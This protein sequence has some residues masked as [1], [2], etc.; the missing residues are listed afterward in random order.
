MLTIE[1]EA[2]LYQIYLLF[3]YL[4]KVILLRLPAKLFILCT[5]ES[6]ELA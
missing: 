2:L 3:M 5:L 6:F 4:C 1:E